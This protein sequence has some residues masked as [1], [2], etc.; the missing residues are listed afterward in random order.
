MLNFL[1]LA[2]G[3]GPPPPEPTDE[4]VLRFGPAAPQV[5][6][7]RGELT[8]YVHDLVHHNRDGRPGRPLLRY[9]CLSA[10]SPRLPVPADLGDEDR[11]ILALLEGRSGPPTDDSELSETRRETRYAM[12]LHVMGPIIDAELA[13]PPCPGGVHAEEEDEYEF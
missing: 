2:L 12:A 8:A 7:V 9:L 11:R 4:D 10:L 3:G 6:V 1:L 5:A 13:R